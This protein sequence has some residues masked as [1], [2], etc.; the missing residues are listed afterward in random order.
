M[1]MK[2]I[3]YL[4]LLPGVMMVAS[5]EPTPKD[6]PTTDDPTPTV[7]TD[8]L[9]TKGLR[10]FEMNEHELNAIIMVPE[11]FD[12]NNH[13]IQPNIKHEEGEARWELTIE[14]NKRWHMVIEDWGEDDCSIAVEKADHLDKS[15]I[16]DFIYDEEGEDYILYSKV[17]KSDN[18]TL[19]E[20]DA[21]MMSNYHFY[22]TK[23]IDGSNVVIKSF[24]MGDFKGVTARQMLT[25][26]RLMKENIK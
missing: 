22:C 2:R 7:K 16:F 4:L 1:K 20:K 19:N 25:S 10:E 13:Y 9:N 12:E 3:A 15:D 23:K 26:A 11:A 17:L 14:S 8:E 21:K 24:E 18:T 6:E 5:C